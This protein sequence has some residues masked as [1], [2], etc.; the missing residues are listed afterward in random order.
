MTLE[1]LRILNHIVEYGTLKLAALK[2]HKTQP[3]LSMAMK[4]L[5][6]ELGFKILDRGNYRLT[7]TPQGKTFYFEAESLLTNA[8]QLKQ[9]GNQLAQD[10]EAKYKIYCEQICPEHLILPSLSSAYQAFPATEFHLQSGLKFTALEEVVQGNADIG[11]GPWFHLFHSQG[12]FESYCIGSFDVI[13]VASPLLLKNN[14]IN[15]IKDLQRLP[16]IVMPESQL[17]WDNEK[18]A[19]NSGSKKITVYDMQVMKT[20]IVEGLGWGLMPYYLIEKELHEEKLKV[21]DIKDK[22]N[23]FTGEIR[24][25]RKANTARGPVSDFFWKKL[26]ESTN[27]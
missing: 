5:E 13:L 18:L 1:Q 19:Y 16:N 10:Y 11:I 6:D 9:L 4:K 14:K 15:V 7:L 21:I 26:K 12:D 2:L 3:A 25:F 23:R 20:L 27:S 22:E 17:D 24:A 8:E